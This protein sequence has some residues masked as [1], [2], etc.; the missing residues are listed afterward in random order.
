[1]LATIFLFH[2]IDVTIST[3]IQTSHYLKKKKNQ[4]LIW[5]CYVNIMG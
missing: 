1:M 5:D 2:N 3:N 4:M